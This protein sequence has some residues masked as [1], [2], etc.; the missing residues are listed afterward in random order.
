MPRYWADRD[1]ISLGWL[2]TAAKVRPAHLT[3]RARSAREFPVPGLQWAVAPDGL[4]WFWVGTHAKH[5][6]FIG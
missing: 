2:G 5:D 4:V 1:S 6:Q 3:L